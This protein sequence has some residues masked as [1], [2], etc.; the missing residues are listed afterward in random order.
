MVALG[1]MLGLGVTK[2]VAEDAKGSVSGTVTGAD[3]K[4]AADVNV[5]VVAAPAKGEKKA[6]DASG[7]KPK[8]A[9]PVAEGK[10]D[11]NGKFDLKDVPAGSYVVQAGS[12]AAGMGREKVTVTAGANAEVS[13][14]LKA[15][16]DAA[17]E[18]HKKHG[19]K[20]GTN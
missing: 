2:A 15:A 7:E 4:P 17:G 12:K 1:L 10:T 6:A 16:G 8:K 3:G 14:T 11:E 9:A 20:D 5:R 18:G 19:K 13:I